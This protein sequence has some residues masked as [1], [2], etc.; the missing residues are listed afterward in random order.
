[1]GNIARDDVPA[2]VVAMGARDDDCSYGCYFSK[3]CCC[4]F[5]LSNA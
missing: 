5:I 2:G 3:K 4:F 1:M